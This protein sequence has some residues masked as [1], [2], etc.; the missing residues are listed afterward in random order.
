MKERT[1]LD[2]SKL[3]LHGTGSASLTFWG[4]GAFMLIEGMGFALTIAVYFYLMSL[5]PRWPIAALLR[6]FFRARC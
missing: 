6:T 2:L 1:A 3:P 4:T 5:A